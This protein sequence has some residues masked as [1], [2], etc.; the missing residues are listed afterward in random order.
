MASEEDVTSDSLDVN[1]TRVPEGLQEYVKTKV[2]EYITKSKDVSMEIH[3]A[4][5]QSTKLVMTVGKN[6]GM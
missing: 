6:P 2:A 5:G 1:V 4:T 3:R